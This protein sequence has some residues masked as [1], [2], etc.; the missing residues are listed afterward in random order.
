MPADVCV[1]LV[2]GPNRETLV[3]IGRALVDERLA[4]CANVLPDL[5]SIF[6][7]EGAVDVSAEAIAILKTTRARVEALCARVAELHPYD[8][9]ECIAL[10]VVAGS[11]RYLAWVHQSVDEEGV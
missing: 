4:A 2:T 3:R 5:T 11:D 1:V 10:D 6:R 9:P 7:W 8:L